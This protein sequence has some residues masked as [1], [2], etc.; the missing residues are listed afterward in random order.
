MD[1]TEGTSTPRA[2]ERRLAEKGRVLGE[3][4][5]S[6]KCGLDPADFPEP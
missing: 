2:G 5:T 1:H 4:P 3:V 6:Q